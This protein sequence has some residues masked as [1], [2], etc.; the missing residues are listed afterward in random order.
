MSLSNKTTAVFIFVIILLLGCLIYSDTLHSPFHFDDIYYIE[1]NPAIANISHIRALAQTMPVPTRIVALLTFAMNYHFHGTEV[2]GY[3]LVNIAIHLIN[4]FLVWWLMMLIWESPVLTSIAATSQKQWMSS[5]AALLFVSHPIQ[6]QAVTYITQRFT[7]LATMFYLLSI[8]FYIKG[9]GKSKAPFWFSVAAVSAVL[10][11]LTKEIVLT[12]PLMVLIYEYFF[13]IPKRN[14]FT[15]LQSC[16]PERLSIILPSS[17]CNSEEKQYR[18]QEPSANRIKILWVVLFFT[19]IIP[20]LYSFNVQGIF[21]IQHSSGSHPGDILTVKTYWLTQFRVITTYIRLLLIP[22]G[23]NL[24][25]DYPA[26]YSLFE[27]ATLAC[28]LFLSCLLVCA[29]LLYDKH[30]MISFGMIWF[31]VTLSVESGVIVIKHVIFEHRVYLPSVGFFMAVSYGVHVLLRQRKKYIMIMFILIAVFS[32]LTYQRNKVWSDD[33]LLWSDVVKKSPFLAKGHLNLAIAYD[34]SGQHYQALDSF[35]RVIASGLDNADTYNSRGVCYLNLGKSSLALSDFD[36]AIELNPRE[37]DF[38]NNRATIYQSQGEYQ[39]ALADFNVA[40][41]L[42]PMH[43]DTLINRAATYG[44]MRQYDLAI[45]DLNRVMEIYPRHVQALVNRGNKYAKLK[46]YQ[47]AIEDYTYAIQLNP[48]FA[49]AYQNRGN[50]Y[51][52]SGE[53]QLAISDYVKAL[54]LEPGFWQVWYS[55]GNAYFKLRQYKEALRDFNRTIEL[56]AQYGPAYWKRSLVHKTLGNDQMAQ[57]DASMARSMGI[58]V[59]DDYIRDT[60]SKAFQAH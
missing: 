6:T 15:K 53:Y 30:R 4:A 5:M 28:F 7:S 8:C 11:M 43:A 37:P 32:L 34:N 18:K 23:Q 42:K 16:N 33:V 21:S 12:L 14:R 40:L 54:G 2:F 17:I 38:Y 45:E 50:A 49:Q 35:D 25:Y 48:G 56:N 26:S 46:L 9:R 13:F 57:S 22:L 36:R 19:L 27:P 58:N 1:R 59:S 39:R 31:F 3:H 60:S 29:L 41:N 52:M 51:E 24:L 20:A 44:Q 10:G 47:R 55:R